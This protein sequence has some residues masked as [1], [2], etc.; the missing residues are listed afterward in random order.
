MANHPT[1]AVVP[2][3]G[4]EIPGD[5]PDPVSVVGV[6]GRET[7]TVGRDLGT[8]DEKGQNPGIDIGGIALSLVIAIGKVKRKRKNLV[9]KM[10]S[11]KKTLL[12]KKS[13][14]L[15]LLPRKKVAKMN[16]RRRTAKREIAIKKTGTRIGTLTAAIKTAKDADPVQRTAHDVVR[17]QKNVAGG[18][19]P[20]IERG[21]GVEK[22][23][24][25][26]LQVIERLKE[27]TIKKKRGLNRKRKNPR[28][29]KVLTLKLK[30][31]TF[32]ILHNQM[33]LSF[34]AYCE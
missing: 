34:M 29:K 3:H 8:A 19:D 6:L 9:K 15:S 30:I 2:D 24:R 5:V 28:P 22:D 14:V 7:D 25:N 10:R 20:G 17:G 11:K 4:T 27:I 26:S 32:P 16:V 23:P 13:F 31:W 18:Q 1:A 12:R 21:A 33:A